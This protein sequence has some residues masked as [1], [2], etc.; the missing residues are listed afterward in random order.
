MST[1]TAK[2]ADG[3]AGDELRP[4]VFEAGPAPAAAGS[5]LVKMGRTHV[6]C[7]ATV[8]NRVPRWMIQQRVAGGW[9][10]AEYSL[11][12]YATAERTAREATQGKLGGRT[13]EIQRLIGRALRSVTRLE[14]LGQRTIWL[15][16]DVI[17]ADGGTRTAAITGAWIA[18]RLAVDRLLDAGDLKENPLTDGVAAVSLGIVDD[19]LRLDLAYEEDSRAAVDMNVIMTHGGRFIEVQGAAE[20]EPFTREQLDGMLALAA[21]GVEQL[22]AAQ[23]AFL[24]TQRRRTVRPA[25]PAT[26]PL[27]TLGD[28]MK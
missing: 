18:L 21:R 7:A 14:K 4:V 5:A 12:P 1:T 19:E 28:L 22:K 15:D 8:E 2:R 9:L 26:P 17:Q 10:T 6:L 27:A 24:E 23:V 3:R 20:R 25:A 16:C 13:Q 11:L